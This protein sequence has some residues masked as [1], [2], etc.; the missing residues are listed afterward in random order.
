MPRENQTSTH[1]IWGLDAFQYAIGSVLR[2]F[3]VFLRKS[4]LKLTFG[5]GLTPIAPRNGV[6]MDE[7]KCGRVRISR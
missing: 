5:Q 4:W 3:W 2:L 1:Y 7:K 6:A